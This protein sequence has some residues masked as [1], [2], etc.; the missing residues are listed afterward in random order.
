MA[1][2]SSVSTVLTIDEG[3]N[4]WMMTSTTLVLLM[5]PGLALFYAGAVGQKNVLNQMYLS[6]ICMA[7]VSVQWVL[8]GF[9]FAFAPNGSHKQ[10][11]SF[12][13]SVFH[14]IETYLV[15]DG[16]YA[17]T[18]PLLTFAAYQATFAIITPAIISGGI[19]GRMKLLPYMIFIVLWST[20]C[21]DPLANW[22]WSQDGQ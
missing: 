13:W 6:M 21:Y 2:G 16:F 22:V 9:S 4:A 18:Y 15:P 17:S 1:T 10:F 20:L 8:F 5:T 19:A 3:D 12:N 7:L 11:G 14:D